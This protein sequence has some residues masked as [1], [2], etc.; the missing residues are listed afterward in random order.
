MSVPERN[1][2]GMVLKLDGWTEQ[3]DE[4]G[5]VPNQRALDPIDQHTTYTI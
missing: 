5:A 4:I 3:T 2:E 1:D